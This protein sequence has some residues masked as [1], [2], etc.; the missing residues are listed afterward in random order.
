MQ[1]HSSTHPDMSDS[2]VVDQAAS[3]VSTMFVVGLAATCLAGV[4]A[5]N[6]KRYGTAPAE[7]KSTYN[8]HKHIE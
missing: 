1:H 4:A 2:E 8:A 3:A 7:G 5:L 6:L